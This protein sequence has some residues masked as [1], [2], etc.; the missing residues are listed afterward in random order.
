MALFDPTILAVAAIAAGVTAVALLVG[1]DRSAG[2]R[3]ARPSHLGPDPADV[4]VELR[5][6]LDAARRERGG[7]ELISDVDLDELARHHAHW[8]ATEE[9]VTSIDDQGRDVVGRRESLLPTLAGP[10]DEAIA[11]VALS[12]SLE[13]RAC[14]EALLVPL[15]VDLWVDGEFT[16]GAIGVST[17]PEQVFASV[18]VAR[19]LAVFDALPD[20]KN[21]RELLV[22][23]QLLEAAPRPPAFQVEEPDGTAVPAEVQEYGSRFELRCRP[24]RAGEHVVRIGGEVFFVFGF[25]NDRLP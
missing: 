24:Q 9:R 18:V 8:M 16:A 20:L 22:S 11:A 12:P 10:L 2:P 6:L 14:A 15:G 21:T 5:R 7:D 25:E 19:R 17:G 3:R 1:R 4:E 13:A 23:G